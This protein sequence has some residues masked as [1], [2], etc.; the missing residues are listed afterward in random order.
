MM[1][2]QLKTQT[3]EKD[4]NLPRYREVTLPRSSSHSAGPDAFPLSLT[5]IAMQ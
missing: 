3:Q 5:V 1:L 4:S 2:V